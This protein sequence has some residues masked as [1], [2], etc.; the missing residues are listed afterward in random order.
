V[1]TISVAECKTF[2]TAPRDTFRARLDGGRS[3]GLLIT[4]QK[5]QGRFEQALTRHPVAGLIRGVED[6]QVATAQAGG[7]D[8]FH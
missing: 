3:F 8:R 5:N 6:P 7:P 4:L 1:G 2:R